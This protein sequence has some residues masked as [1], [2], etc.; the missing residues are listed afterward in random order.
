M[1]G[2]SVQYHSNITKDEGRIFY[3]KFITLCEVFCA[4]TF[5][6][7]S[8]LKLLSASLRYSHKPS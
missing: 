7:L 3:E 1:K 2:R 8:R 6:L 5:V 4:S